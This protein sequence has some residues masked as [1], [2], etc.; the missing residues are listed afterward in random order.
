MFFEI[1][2]DVLIF[3]VE[4]LLL[5]KKSYGLRSSLEYFLQQHSKINFFYRKLLFKSKEA[6]CIFIFN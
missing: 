6:V 5:F 2:V 1:V 3:V 4:I